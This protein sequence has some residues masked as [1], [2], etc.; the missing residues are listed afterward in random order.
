MK[1]TSNILNTLYKYV[2][3]CFTKKSQPSTTAYSEIII[4]PTQQPVLR[5]QNA[6]YCVDCSTPDEV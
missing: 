2:F 6:E 5:R 1:M 3:S 4:F